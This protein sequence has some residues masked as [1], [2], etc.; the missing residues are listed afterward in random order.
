MKKLWSVVLWGMI[1]GSVWAAE[2][3]VVAP[4]EEA[5]GV[6]E[7]QRAQQD[8]VEEAAERCLGLGTGQPVQSAVRARD[9][10]VKTGRDID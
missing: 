8:G 6:V 9:E 1:A 2:P 7:W 10:S 5:L 4:D 3:P